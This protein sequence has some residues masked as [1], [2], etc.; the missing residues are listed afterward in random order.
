MTGTM[1]WFRSV[2]EFD[3][4]ALDFAGVEL[5]DAVD[6]SEGMGD[7]GVGAGGAEV[8][9]GEAFEDFVGEAVGGFDGELK[10]GGIG[11]ASAV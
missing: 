9:G 1:P 8:V 2:K 5:I 4:E 10:G 3:I 7:D 6:D 11:D